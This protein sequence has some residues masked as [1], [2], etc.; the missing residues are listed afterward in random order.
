M[1]FAPNF[2]KNWKTRQLKFESFRLSRK[3][4][5]RKIWK[6]WS[7]IDH[8]FSRP[9]LSPNSSLE[10]GGTF[11]AY[12]HEISK[13]AFPILHCHYYHRIKMLFARLFFKECWVL[14]A[15]LLQA[16]VCAMPKRR[17][18]L[19]CEHTFNNFWIQ[20]SNYNMKY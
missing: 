2:W 1:C 19:N 11:W 13:L 12:L 6:N 7:N 17:R 14:D 9:L 3:E 4:I 18:S 15:L 20:Y 10:I 16:F 5:D 8:S